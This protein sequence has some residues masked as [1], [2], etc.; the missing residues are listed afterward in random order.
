MAEC[1]FCKTQLDSEHFAVVAQ[2]IED[3]MNWTKFE[4]DHPSW[5]I[6][7]NAVISL[8]DG[9]TVTL[10]ARKLKPLADEME[11]GYFT[12]G[13]EYPQ[14]TEFEVF[15]VLQYGDRYFKKSGTADSYGEINWDSGHVTEV[16]PKLVT[17]TVWE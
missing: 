13:S 4:S 8:G 14:G 17:A 3:A 16:K 10:V 7:D 5:G 9:K 15:V 1:K 12:S 6:K 11:D 2:T